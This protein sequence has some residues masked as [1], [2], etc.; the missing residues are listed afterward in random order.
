MTKAESSGDIAT[1]RQIASDSPNEEQR[2]YMLAQIDRDQA[3]RSM[4][5]DQMAAIQQRLSSLRNNDERIQ[6]LLYVASR[7]GGNDRKAAL[8]LANQAGQIID[9][10]PPGKSQLERQIALAMLYCSLKSDRG[11]AIMESLIPKL[12][13]LVAAAAALEGFE[14][15]YLREGE[16]TMTSAGSIGRLLTGLAQNAGY[17]AGSDFDR[18]VTLANQF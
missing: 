11:F 18:S 9:S 17:F 1:A 2:R 16:W 5:A 10:T 4:N 13:E 8:G 6:F 15:N 3:W 7:V 12:N 14:N